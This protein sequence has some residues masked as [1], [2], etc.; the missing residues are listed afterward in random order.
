MCRRFGFLHSRVLL[1]RQ[2]EL[3]NLENQLIKMDDEDKEEC[4]LGLK[5]REFDELRDDFE[6]QYTRKFLINTIDQKLKEYGTLVPSSA[7]VS[8]SNLKKTQMTL[9]EGFDLLFR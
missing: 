3:S 7:C 9:C 5:S 6:E 2:D 8:G 1:Y 4:P